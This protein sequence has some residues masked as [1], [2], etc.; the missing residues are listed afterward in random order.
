MHVARHNRDHLVNQEEPQLTLRDLPYVGMYLAVPE[1][2]IPERHRH[3]SHD[4]DN[5]M[6]MRALLASMLVPVYSDDHAGN[7]PGEDV[8]SQFVASHIHGKERVRECKTLMAQWAQTH[9]I[10]LDEPELMSAL[11]RN[12]IPAAI[13][14]TRTF[15]AARGIVIRDDWR[16]VPLSDEEFLKNDIEVRK[17]RLAFIKVI[18]REQQEVEYGSFSLYHGTQFETLAKILHESLMNTPPDGLHPAGVYFHNDGH[19]R[20]CL[21]YGHGQPVGEDMWWLC[22]QP[23]VE[24]HWPAQP[25]TYSRK[26]EQWIVP[27]ELTYQRIN[28]LYV[29]AYLTCA[30]GDGGWTVQMDPASSP[31]FAPYTEPKLPRN[32]AVHWGKGFKQILEWGDPRN[33]F[34]RAFTGVTNNVSQS[35][36]ANELPPAANESPSINNSSTSSGANECLPPPA[37]PNS[38]AS[39]PASGTDGSSNTSPAAPRPAVTLVARKLVTPPQE[40]IPIPPNGPP[41][42]QPPPISGTP[43]KPPPMHLR[44]YLRGTHDAHTPVKAPPTKAPPPVP[45]PTPP[46]AP[47]PAPRRAAPPTPATPQAPLTASSEPHSTPRAP[48]QSRWT[49]R[50][51]TPAAK[52][53]AYANE[54]IPDEREMSTPESAKDN[55]KATEGTQ[56]HPAVCPCDVATAPTSSI[57]AT[58]VCCVQV[59]RPLLHFEEG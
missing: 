55:T 9:G 32:G 8:P 15:L 24:C 41:V 57:V 44:A 35:P 42:K 46:P 47:S 50:H 38:W 10:S 21:N 36:N 40:S 39:F 18:L 56:P 59:D 16:F 58:P 7:R 30:N 37:V 34:L 4:R 20:K 22:L 12:L 49:L 27:E 52:E 25:E 28:N 33:Q 29:A 14:W 26:G 45:T 5:C 13:G 48:A 51:W 23:I 1:A 6:V 53:E 43:A 3:R 17:G 11:S 2:S 54:S 31:F 19:K